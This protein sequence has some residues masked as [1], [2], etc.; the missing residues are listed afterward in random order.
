MM[1]FRCA[2]LT[3]R[4]AKSKDLSLTT[5][6]FIFNSTLLK[7]ALLVSYRADNR[8]NNTI[9]EAVAKQTMRDFDALPILNF[10]FSILFFPLHP[11]PR[12]GYFHLVW[13]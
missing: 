8:L 1:F 12:L 3:T 11:D 13:L 5:F 9:V 7:A 10:A 6:S 4:S 2:S